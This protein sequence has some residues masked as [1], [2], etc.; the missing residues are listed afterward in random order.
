MTTGN[1]TPRTGENVTDAQICDR[2]GVDVSNLYGA[3][4]AAGLGS[5][6]TQFDIVEADMGPTLA[7]V[8]ACYDEV[9]LDTTV[10]GPDGVTA[11]ALAKL[12][13]AQADELAEAL[14]RAA[15]DVRAYSEADE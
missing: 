7:F 2:F 1:D 6:Q 3:T 12:T 5:V 15:E 9:L 10:E 8:D 11:G 14:H 4:V 13:P